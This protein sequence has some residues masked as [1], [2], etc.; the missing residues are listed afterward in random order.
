MG[1]VIG[2]KTSGVGVA[3]ALALAARGDEQLFGFARGAETLPQ[4]RSE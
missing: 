4:G 2:G 3:I 1:R